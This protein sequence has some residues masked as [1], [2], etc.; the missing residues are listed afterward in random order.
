[1]FR[2]AETGANGRGL[3]AT[4]KH[5]SVPVN[6]NKK[7][8]KA[9]RIGVKRRHVEKALEERASIKRG[10]TEQAKVGRFTAEEEHPFK[11]VRW[12]KV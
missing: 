12:V 4:V 2:L 8:I 6:A 11:C 9:R 5:N 7:S 3:Y 1:M 10:A